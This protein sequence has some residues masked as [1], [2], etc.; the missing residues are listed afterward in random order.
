MNCKQ[1]QEV[2]PENQSCEHQERQKF[3]LRTNQ[4]SVQCESTS[5]ANYL[6]HPNP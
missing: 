5:S 1:M 6:H 2:I 4:S 3:P